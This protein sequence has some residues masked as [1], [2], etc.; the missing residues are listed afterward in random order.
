MLTSDELVTQI[1]RYL[2]DFRLDTALFVFFAYV[3]ADMLY[4]RYTLAIMKLQSVPAAT[5]GAVMYF[6]LATGILSYTTNPLYLIPLILG[7]WVGTFLTVE[8]ERRKVLK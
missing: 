6:L 7:S 1:T 5:T 4:A 8:K 3:I 2:A